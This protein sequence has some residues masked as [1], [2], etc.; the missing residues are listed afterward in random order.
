MYLLNVFL[1][2]F[3]KY[4]TSAKDFTMQQKIHLCI[5]FLE[6]ARPQSQFP[7]S[8]VWER[9]IYFQDRSTYF[10]HQNR[11]IDR[12]NIKIAHRHMTVEI[13]TVAAQFLSGIICLFQIFGIDSLQCRWKLLTL[14]IFCD[15]PYFDKRHIEYICTQITL[16]T[17]IKLSTNFHKRGPADAAK[18]VGI[19][20]MFAAWI[21]W[22][23]WRIW[24]PLYCQRVDSVEVS[25]ILHNL[26]LSPW[27]RVP[28]L[29]HYHLPN[30]PPTYSMMC[31]VNI[32]LDIFP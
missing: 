24:G 7:H 5:P 30:Y 32:L 23:S 4:Q 13:G 3:C 27:P 2:Y 15:K 21:V 10:L 20:R 8:C 25:S 19:M 16:E 18:I 14:M 29:P 31:V 28:G 1:F 22:K 17:F 11:Q 6:I 12:G 26:A 9:F